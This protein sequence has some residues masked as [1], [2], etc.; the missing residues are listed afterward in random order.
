DSTEV[1]HINNQIIMPEGITV[2][3][4]AFDVTPH[5][6]ITGIVTEKKVMVNNLQAE[7]CDLFS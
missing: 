3:N 5:E 1:T 7:I 4:P 6:L 2:A